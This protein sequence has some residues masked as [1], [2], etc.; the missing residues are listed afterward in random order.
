MYLHLKGVALPF[1]STLQP[2]TCSL[3]LGRSLCNFFFLG[4]L[5]PPNIGKH[6]FFV[7]QPDLCPNFFDRLLFSQNS[8]ATSVQPEE[9]SAKMAQTHPCY[10]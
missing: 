4:L 10:V 2:L 9:C 8:M 1:P 5:L 6:F 3:V 7:I